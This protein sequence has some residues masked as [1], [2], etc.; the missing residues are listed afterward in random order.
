[1]NKPRRPTLG[2]ALGSG[3]ARGLAHIGVLK[4]LEQ[5]EIAVHL[6]AG[7][8]IGG[9]IAAGY[10]AGLSAEYME[11]EALRFGGLRNLAKLVDLS[12]PRAGF[13]EGHRI[14]AYFSERLSKQDFEEL[15]IPL[16]IIAADLLTGEEVIVD[17]GNLSQ[18][19]RATISFPSVLVPVEVEGRLLID[20]GVVN[21]VPADVVRRMGAQIVM[22]VDV[23]ARPDKPTPFSRDYPRRFPLS[24]SP[25]FVDT[26][27]K[28][29]IIMGDRLKRYRLKEAKPEIVL[30]PLLSD[31][32]DSFGAFYHAAECIAAGEKAM[33]AA[34]HILR[35]HLRQALASES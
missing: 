30:Q 13:I 23:S 25:Q 20:G 4:V 31:E 19:L 14:Q 7:T 32:C 1:M 22:A 10:A 12:L 8:S 21:P 15:D 24:P 18:A 34:L 26:L 6:L 9:V 27:V 29:V 17:S 16:T 33:R 3:G 11:K 2:V 35:E 28:S 5:E